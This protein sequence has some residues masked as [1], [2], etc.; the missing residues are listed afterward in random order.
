MPLIHAGTQARELA[1]E[2]IV[3]LRRCDVWAYDAV[4]GEDYSFKPT[5]M[6]YMHVSFFLVSALIL[7]SSD[8]ENLE[9]A[10]F[11]CGT[12]TPA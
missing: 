10:S 2:L 6:C 3:R 11:Q 12:N 1:Y 5:K 9:R 8:D 7:F 4:D